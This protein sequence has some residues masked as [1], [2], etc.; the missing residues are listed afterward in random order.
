MVMVLP[1]YEQEQPGRPLQ[2]RG[3]HRRR[4]HLPR[5]V[6]QDPHPAGQGLLG[7]V[8]LPAREPGVPGLRHR[9]RTG[10]GLHLLRPP[11]P[12]GLA[13]PRPRRRPDRLQ[14]VGDQPRPVRLPVAARADRRGRGQHVLRRRHQPRRRRAARR[15][16][17]LRHELLRRPAGPVRGRTRLGPG[18][19]SWWCATSTSTCIEEVRNQWAFYRDRRPD[20]YGP[21]TA[22]L[23]VRRDDQRRPHRPVPRASCRRGWRSTTTSRSSL[24]RGQGRHVWDVDGNRYLDFFGGILTT[25]DRPRRP[26]GLDGHPG[27][28]GKVLHTSTLYL[29]A[30]DGRARRADRAAVRHPRREGLL[31]HRRGPRPTTPRC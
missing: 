7:E 19:R 9:R 16:R 12:G 23:S 11:L 29:V 10:R 24:D 31:H 20:A 13:R 30:A 18:R 15:Q 1:V 4:R 22:G 2:H 27:P 14:P 25:I 26:R 17:L 3:G 5:Q 8:L 6:P 28:G 21:L